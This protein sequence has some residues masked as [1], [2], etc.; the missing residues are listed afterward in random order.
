MN[1]K[2]L[3][4]KILGIVP[5]WEIRELLLDLKEERIDIE[6]VLKE[7][8]DTQ[9][10][11]CHREGK[12]NLCK[13]HDRRPERIWRHLDTCQFKTFI[14]CRIPRVR[15]PEHGVLSLD[16]PW[17]EEQD[18]FS[19]LFESYAI[20]LL[21]VSQNRRR[22][23]EILRISWDEMDGIM[24]R[25]VTR[26]LSRRKVE[27]IP[28]VGMDEKSSLKGHSYVT[29]LVDHEHRCVLDVSPGR[30]LAAVTSLWTRLTK[31]Q[32]QS[33]KAVSMDFWAAYR[34]GAKEHVPQ[35]DIVHDKF[36]ISKYL[37][38]SVDKV[39]RQEQH[40][41]KK[42]KD[43]SLSGT[44]YLW[45]KRQDN[46][47]ERDIKRYAE[48][49]NLQLKVGRAWNRKELFGEFFLAESTDEAREFFK[50]W[51]FSAT[52]S[53]LAPVIKVAKMFKRYLEGLLNW[54]EHKLSNGLTEGLNSRIQ[55]LKSVARGFRSFENYRTAIL[56]H[57][58]G[59]DMIPH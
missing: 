16:V 49:S 57:L 24:R 20:H 53:R 8:A 52:H 26:G 13:I 38:D 48:L 18:R 7:G 9:C 37:N 3:Y 41:L 23:A 5:P 6:V 54:I 44:K 1:E 50:R 33:V 22:S 34:R 43:T 29:V 59:L 27:P 19:L 14:R 51:Y 30:D 2:E 40:L 21:Q 28:Y 31:E 36:H 32:R 10:P 4:T 17:A 12:T 39:R 46:W 58:G 11:A 25:G 56:F 47:T 15:C 42:Q 35:A 45:L 55:Q